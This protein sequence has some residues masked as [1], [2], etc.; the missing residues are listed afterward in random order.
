MNTR[1][2]LKRLN[3]RNV[4]NLS[5][6]KRRES[7]SQIPTDDGTSNNA[8]FNNKVVLSDFEN[9]IKV[10]DKQQTETDEKTEFINLLLPY[11]KDFKITESVV[12]EIPIPTIIV[13]LYDFNN[14]A[15]KLNNLQ[16]K[17]L[18]NKV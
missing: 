17:R 5:T 13:L 4:A 11:I 10:V 14:L 2:Y 12:D 8:P 9:A 1:E 18:Q 15:D 7:I 6:L 16:G 3:E